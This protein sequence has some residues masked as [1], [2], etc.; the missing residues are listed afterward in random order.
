[1]AL[2]PHEGHKE[3]AGCVTSSFCVGPGAE[4]EAAHGCPGVGGVT[5]ETTRARHSWTSLSANES[6]VIRFSIY[7]VSFIF[8]SKLRYDQRL[9]LEYSGE[10][11]ESFQEK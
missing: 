10:Q 8:C 7:P 6:T 4:T 9:P 3:S 1:M 5:A 11:E 2:G